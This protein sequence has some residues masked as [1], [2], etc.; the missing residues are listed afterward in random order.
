[1]P[2]A[3]FYLGEDELTVVIE[4]SEMPTDKIAEARVGSRYSVCGLH[5]FKLN[6]LSMVIL[7]SYS[8][9]PHV[10]LHDHHQVR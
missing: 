5:M 1:M 2:V 3:E 8:T 10:D 6:L 7:M 9:L 4:G